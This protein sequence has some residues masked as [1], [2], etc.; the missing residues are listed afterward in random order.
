M[1]DNEL[2]GFFEEILQIKD[3]WYIKDI[4]NKGLEVEIFIDFKE[5]N[6]FEYEGELFPVHDTVEQKERHLNLFQYKAYI[7]TRVP[8]IMTKDGIKAVEPPKINA[9]FGV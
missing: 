5:K 4:E 6:Q 8:R 1:K 9:A 2:Q 3:P 7:T